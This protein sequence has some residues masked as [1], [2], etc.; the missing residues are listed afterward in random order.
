MPSFVGVR[1]L[2]L[3]RATHA[4]RS[5]RLAVTPTSA[6]LSRGYAKP[7]LPGLSVF[8]LARAS[9]WVLFRVGTVLLVSSL[10]STLSV[11]QRERVFLSWRTG[12]YC[13]GGFLERVTRNTALDWMRQLREA[14]QR[15]HPKTLEGGAPREA[16][17]AGGGWGADVSRSVCRPS[18]RT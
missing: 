2:A 18:P 14:P 10:M 16:V 13:R 15:P 3:L 1:S 11:E 9:G 7:T 4:P 5:V 8:V 6:R 12:V 17:V